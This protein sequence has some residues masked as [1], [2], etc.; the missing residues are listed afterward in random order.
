MGCVQLR[1]VCGGCRELKARAFREHP[2]VCRRMAAQDGGKVALAAQA[3]RPEAEGVLQTG[4]G[5]VD[6][7]RPR[8]REPGSLDRLDGKRRMRVQKGGDDAFVFLGRERAGG[9]DEPPAEA[10]ISAAGRISTAAA[11]LR[12]RSL[13]PVRYGG[14]LL[15]E[16]ALAGAGG[17][18]KD[19]VKIAGKRVSLA[20]CSPNRAFGAARRSRRA[21]A[22]GADGSRC[23]RAGRCPAWRRQAVSSCRRARHEVIPLAGLR[24]QQARR[25]H[26]TRL[27]QIVC[28][29]V[30]PRV[31]AGAAALADVIAVRLPRD[32]RLAERERSAIRQGLARIQTQPGAHELVGGEIQRIPLRRAGAAFVPG[33]P[34]AA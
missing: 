18:D 24:V 27:L 15:P 6:P 9:I 33:S 34:A 26:G 16:H 5:I 1:G 30:M 32:L 19:A 4:R 17:V 13:A 11:R 22:R 31:Q 28:A 14:L 7:V 12:A 8:R 3:M 23:T 29:C 20:R 25:G 10:S 21:P 2:A